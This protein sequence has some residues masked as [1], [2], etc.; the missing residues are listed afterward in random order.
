MNDFFKYHGLGNDYL[1]LEPSRFRGTLSGQAV[2]LIC[3]R[4]RGIGADGILWGPLESE[5]GAPRLRIFNPDGSEAEKSGNGLR[6]FARH[7][8]ERR[9]V[10]QRRFVIAVSGDKV[11][12]EVLDESG[13]E[14]AVAMGHVRFD[15]RSIPMTGPPRDV[16]RE[17]LQAGGQAWTIS[18]ANVGNPHCVV[19]V[20]EPTEE[21]AW[22]I[23]PLIE[24]H[25]SFPQRANVQFMRKL[26]DH[27][28]QIEIWERGAGYTSASGSSSCA[29]AAVARR[30]GLVQSP[31]TVHMPGGTLRVDLDP[32]YRAR[33]TGPVAAI[34]RGDFH[35]DFLSELGLAHR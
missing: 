11:E 28:I 27:A 13:A 17:T 29:A 4:N 1:V 21:L 19:P 35:P 25:A 23:G 3:H 18:A 30:L 7:L 16:L 15:S 26:D 31:V 5:G 32:D 14:L 24:R 20:P 12:A 22:R 34:S 8:W 10:N 9:L 6:I 2:R 33:L